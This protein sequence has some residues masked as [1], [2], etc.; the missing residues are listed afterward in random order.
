METIKGQ[1]ETNHGQGHG[2]LVD[3]KFLL[4]F[5]LITSLFFLWGFSRSVLDVLNKHFQESMHV[6]ISRSMLV[7]ASTYVAY[8]LMAIPAGMMITRWGYRRGLVFGLSLFAI[9]CFMFIPGGIAESF[10]LF[11]GA[12]FVIGCG[13]ATLET[14]ANPYAAELGSPETVASRLNLSQAFNGLGCMLGPVIVGGFLFSDKHASVAVPYTIMGLLVA[15]M[16]FLFTRVRLPEIS[17]S[18]DGTEK[19][20][21]GKCQTDRNFLQLSKELWRTR[22]FVWGITALFFYEIAEIGINSIFINYVTADGWLDKIA[23]TKVLSFGALGV[24]MLS[25]VIGS[26]VMRRIP[27]VKVLMFCGAMTVIGALLTALVSGSVGRCG[28]FM[29]YLFEAIMFPT[30]FAMTI[31]KVGDKAKTA[32]AYLMMTPL[33]GAV[34]AWLMG[35]LVH[36]GDMSPAFFIPAIAYGVVFCYTIIGYK[37]GLTSR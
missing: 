7:Q 17:G 37:G 2:K 36:E 16:A 3:S 20:E 13:L 33:G 10:G 6:S 29:C 32:S 8:A 12:L 19:T 11:L 24:F 1:K 23:A 14:A 5:I 22:S 26:M 4:P 35:L 30:I 9:G 34:G 21:S 25:R 15:A 28:L 27:A 31:S 18:K